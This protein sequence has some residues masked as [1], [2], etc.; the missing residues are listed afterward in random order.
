VDYIEHNLIPGEKILFKTRLHSIT[1]FVHVVMG[2]IF[3]MIG[4]YCLYQYSMQRNDPA[5]QFMAWGIAGGVLVLF[6]AATIIYAILKRNATEMAVTNRRILIKTGF[7][8]HRTVELLLM[9]VESIV[10]N[11]PFF[12][13]MLGYGT[14]VIRGTG[15]TPEAFDCIARPKEFRRCVQ[16]QIEATQGQA[17]AAGAQDSS[18]PTA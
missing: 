11:E 3:A 10:I 6:G 9:R 17:R 5:S 1:I 18:A 15:G 8:S 7:L 4:F 16:E 12:G 2:L 13:R 14:V